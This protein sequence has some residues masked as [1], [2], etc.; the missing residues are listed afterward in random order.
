MHSMD[1]RVG[2]LE[3]RVRGTGFKH[4]LLERPLSG[5]DVI[6]LCMSGGWVTGRYEWAGEAQL[7]RFHFSVELGEGRVW[8]SS[9]ALPEGAL[10][11]WA[12]T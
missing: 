10:V 4:Y 8:E 12:P 9:F 5:G 3:L 7:P 6:E 1:E 2:Q 11:R